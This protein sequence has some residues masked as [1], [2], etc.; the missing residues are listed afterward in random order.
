MYLICFSPSYRSYSILYIII[1]QLH[2]LAERLNLL[3]LL[4]TVGASSCDK[5]WNVCVVQ[6]CNGNEFVKHF[7]FTIFY[8][9]L[10]H[11]QIRQME[12]FMAMHAVI[13]LWAVREFH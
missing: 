4:D 7:D 5:G 3:A 10:K 9:C 13:N 8:L 2:D 6:W 11:R 1:L 12:D